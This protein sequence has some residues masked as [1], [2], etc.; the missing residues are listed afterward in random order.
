MTLVEKMRGWWDTT[1]I[2]RDSIALWNRMGRINIS[3]RLKRYIAKQKG[4]YSAINRP[5]T[6]APTVR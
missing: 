2:G 5:L 4:P 3:V 6:S 1:P